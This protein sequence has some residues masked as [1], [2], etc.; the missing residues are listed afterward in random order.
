MYLAVEAGSST[1]NERDVR[2]KAHVIDMSPRSKVIKRIEDD[3]E[4]LK[5]VNVELSVHDIRM[6]CFELRTGLKLLRNFLRY[7]YSKVQLSAYA[8]I[9][10]FA[11]T[12][13]GEGSGG[14]DLARE[15]KCV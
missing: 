14:G 2:C 13:W 11:C 10:K 8:H 15:R 3:I 6:V 7:L 5:P 9:D 4:S 12:A 1:F